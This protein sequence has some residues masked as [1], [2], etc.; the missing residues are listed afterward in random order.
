[1]LLKFFILVVE[2]V[3]RN[4][5]KRRKGKAKFF[6]SEKGFGFI[7]PDD[8]GEDVFVHQSV[9]KSDGYRSLWPGEAVEFEVSPS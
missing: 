3:Q 2:V 1:M 8:G 9:I 6:N 5:P 4:Q 7:T